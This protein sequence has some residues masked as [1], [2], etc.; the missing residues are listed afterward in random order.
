MESLALCSSY[1]GKLKSRKSL[2]GDLVQ[3]TIGT[4]SFCVHKSDQY[5]TLLRP[6][7]TKKKVFV[8]V[9]ETGQEYVLFTDEINSDSY[10]LV[11]IKDVKISD[12]YRLISKLQDF[13]SRY[14]GDDF[15]DVEEA[16]P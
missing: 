2:S 9:E 5:L 8:A 6:R 1:W 3:I 15:V 10:A 4:H 7:K 12:S 13:W 16:A 11:A 14:R